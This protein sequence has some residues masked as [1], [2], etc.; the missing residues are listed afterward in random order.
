[1]PPPPPGSCRTAR[2][3][4]PGPPFPNIGVYRI[5]AKFGA[6]GG[7][8]TAIMRK[9]QPRARRLAQRACRFNTDRAGPR[10]LELPMPMNSAASL[11]RSSGAA[12]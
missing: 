10:R 7:P 2:A 12:Q 6:S 5:F 3:I 11:S 9:F 4:R 1:M 8:R